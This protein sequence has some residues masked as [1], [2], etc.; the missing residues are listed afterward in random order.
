MRSRLILLACV[1]VALLCTT[2]HRVWGEVLIQHVGSTNP[3]TEGWGTV[4]HA[5]LGGTRSTEAVWYW[6]SIGGSTTDGYR[7]KSGLWAA[8][9]EM[10]TNG[11]VAEAR[12]EYGG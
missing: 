5:G 6:D 12:M 7:V 1:A 4:S 10:T 2:D 3:T 11:W 8:N 9:P